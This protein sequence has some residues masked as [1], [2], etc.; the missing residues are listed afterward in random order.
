MHDDVKRELL[1]E[2]LDDPKKQEFIEL[3]AKPGYEYLPEVKEQ[4]FIKTHFPF[5]LLP[6]SVMQKEAKVCWQIFKFLCARFC[7]NN[8][9][10]NPNTR[11]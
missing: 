5:S 9:P 11:Q 1:N 2:N 3:V 7:V 4:R 6:P 10:A 8:K